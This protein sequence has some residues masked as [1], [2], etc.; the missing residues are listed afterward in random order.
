MSD[1]GNVAKSIRERLGSNTEDRLG[2]ALSELLE[3]PLL[4][5]AI[6][7]AFDAR[8]KASQAQEVAMGALNLPSAADIER[9]TRR[10]RAVSHR[11]EGIEDGVDRLDRALTPSGVEARLAAIE[12]RISALSDKLDQALRR[13]APAAQRAGGTSG[14]GGRSAERA[15]GPT[16]AG[17]AATGSAGSARAARPAGASKQTRRGAG[18]AAPKP[19]RAKQLRAA[20]EAKAARAGRTAKATKAAKA[21]KGPAARSRAGRSAP[22]KT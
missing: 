13:P 6:G 5:G 9:L 4:T 3:N 22:G 18:G 8:E 16:S 17:A 12:T 10:L 1:A 21:A 15:S 20:K 7:R 19:S 14:S 2:K 11:L